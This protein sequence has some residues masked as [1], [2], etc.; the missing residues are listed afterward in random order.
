MNHPDLKPCFQPSTVETDRQTG[1]R[2]FLVV[3]LWGGGGQSRMFTLQA[4]SVDLFNQGDWH[5]LGGRDVEF[6]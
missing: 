2:F 3:D 5:P 1:D 6:I 4:L